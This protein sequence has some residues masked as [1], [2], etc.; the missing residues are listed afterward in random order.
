MLA[1]RDIR[2]RAPARWRSRGHGAGDPAWPTAAGSA[3]HAAV[4]GR[5]G[6]PRDHLQSAG[7]SGCLHVRGSH[8][9][10]QQSFEHELP[11][12]RPLANQIGWNPDNSKLIKHIEQAFSLSS[13]TL[14]WIAIAL[15]GYA[16]IELVEAVGLSL[17]RRW[18]EYFAMIATCV[19]IGL[20]DS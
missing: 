19:A 15:A 11:L 8:E 18:G 4:G 16:L 7:P 12:I 14:M 6:D 13:S 2:G 5:A 3:D 1:V 20:L 17:M 9:R 10:L